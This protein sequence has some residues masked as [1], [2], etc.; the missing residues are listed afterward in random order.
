M[1]YVHLNRNQLY[2]RSYRTHNLWLDMYQKKIRTPRVHSFHIGVFKRLAKTYS[3]VTYKT[4][5]NF[6]IEQSDGVLVGLDCHVP[7]QVLPWLQE[8]ARGGP[9]AEGGLQQTHFN[10]LEELVRLSHKNHV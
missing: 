5:I 7:C 3:G 10:I 8:E 1:W 2:Q 6:H 9:E 4:T